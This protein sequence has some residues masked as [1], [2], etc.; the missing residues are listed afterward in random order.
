MRSPKSR[1]NSARKESALKARAKQPLHDRELL[2]L[3]EDDPGSLAI[4][5]A[6][7]ATQPVPKVKPTLRRRATLVVVLAAAVFALLAAFELSS[8]QAGVIQKAIAALPPDR[9]IHLILFDER[10][11][12][13]VV[14]LRRGSSATEHHSVE[15]WFDPRSGS[16]RVR[17]LVG[18]VVVSDTELRSHPVPRSAADAPLDFPAIYRSALAGATARDVVKTRIGGQ[19]VYR[20]RFVHSRLLASVVIDK[21]TYRPVVIAF[22]DGRSRR[23]FRVTAM[24]QLPRRAYLPKARLSRMFVRRTPVARSTKIDPADN[25]APKELIGLRKVAVSQLVFANG[26]TGQRITFANTSIAG[27][28]PSHYA[29]FELAQAPYQALSWKGEAVVLARGGGLV[30][31]KVGAA[32]SGYLQRNGLFIHVMA[33]GGM[34]NVISATREFVSS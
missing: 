25:L 32:W 18:G 17:D 21:D 31:E 14:D 8:S 27:K 16:R 26:D 12:Y 10:A 22:R 6:I 15:E 7:A 9:I 34:A 29:R 28:L 5:D 23:V 13:R 20:I 2:E 4:V 11:A 3:F 30:V 1:K 24:S 19:P 33:S